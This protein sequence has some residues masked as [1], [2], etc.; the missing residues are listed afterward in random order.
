MLPEDLELSSA[1][2]EYASL[3]FVA[4]DKLYALN[5]MTSYGENVEFMGAILTELTLQDN[6]DALSQDLRRGLGDMVEFYDNSSYP[7]QPDIII[8]MKGLAFARYYDFHGDC[9]DD[10]HRPG[11]RRYRKFDEL[12]GFIPSVPYKDSTLLAETYNPG[13]V[14]QPG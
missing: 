12:M 11:H 3:P 4:D 8:G 14:H 6:G 10:G 1:S 13:P 2:F 7:V 9:K 5:L